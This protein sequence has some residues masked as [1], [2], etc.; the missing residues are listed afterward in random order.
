MDPANAGSFYYAVCGEN[1]YHSLHAHC[2][3]QAKTPLRELSHLIL[4]GVL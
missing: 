4:A 2:V 3:L 1:Y